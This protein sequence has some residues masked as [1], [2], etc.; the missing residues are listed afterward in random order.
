MARKTTDALLCATNPHQ[1]PNVDILTPPTTPTKDSIDLPNLSVNDDILSTS[2]TLPSLE[3]FIATLID[4]SNVQVPTLMSTLVYLER[5]RVK[6]PPVAKGMACTRHRVFLATLIVASKYLND[7]SPKNKHWARHA[8]LFSVAEVNLMERQLLSFLNFD[9]DISENEIYREFSPF[10]NNNKFNPLYTF[11]PMP[12]TPIFYH[13]LYNVNVNKHMRSSQHHQHLRMQRSHPTLR[14]RQQLEIS[15]VKPTI[16]ITPSHHS[17]KHFQYSNHH[18][19]QYQNQNYMPSL[20]ALASPPPTPQDY[21]SPPSKLPKSSH[22]VSSKIFSKL[23]R[24][25]PSTQDM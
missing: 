23:I 2:P 22:F 16:S 13:N 7:S 25:K 15:P 12:T 20:L 21:K 5:L 24:R 11:Q 10:F 3:C 18:Q 14:T 19:P 4:Q 1:R 17:M 8:R 9:L 6:L